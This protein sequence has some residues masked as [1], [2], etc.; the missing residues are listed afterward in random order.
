MLELVFFPVWMREMEAFGNDDTDTH[1]RILIGSQSF[2]ISP[3]R[4]KTNGAECSMD[5]EM[6]FLTLMSAVG[7]SCSALYID[8]T[9][10]MR[11]KHSNC[12]VYNLLPLHTSTRIP[13]V[14][15]C[16]HVICVYSRFSMDKDYFLNS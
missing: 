4:K 14:Y 16:E 12:S 3:L 10:Y 6:T 1:V 15:M 11:R 9:L 13:S 5:N 2:L 8:T 7:Q